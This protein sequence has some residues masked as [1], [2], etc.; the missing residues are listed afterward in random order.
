[1]SRERGV[2]TQTRTVN[3]DENKRKSN[4][5]ECVHSRQKVES[6]RPHY[7]SSNR[8]RMYELEIDFIKLSSRT[9]ENTEDPNSRLRGV[10]VRM[11]KTAPLAPRHG[12]RGRQAPSNQ[13]IVIQEVR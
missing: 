7:E 4:Q 2:Q 1:M 10:T 3:R 9:K 8:V 13:L 11:K 5:T 6:E 12:P